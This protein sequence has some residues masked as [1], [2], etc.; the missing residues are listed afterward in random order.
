MPCDG[1][2]IFEDPIVARILNDN[3]ISIKVDREERPDLDSIYM[4]AVVAMTGQGGWPLSV[5]LTPAGQPFF[6]GT[7]FPPERRANLPSFSDVLRGVIK[8]WDENRLNVLE[9]GD[10][11]ANYLK[12][13][14]DLN[15]DQ[16]E[17][18]FQTLEDAKKVLVSTYD[19]RFGG[20]GS[21]PKFPQPM[22]I[23]FLIRRA[24]RGDES[25]LK[26]VNH[27]LAAMSQGGMFDLVGGGFHRYSTDESWYVPHFEK[28]LY[29]NAQLSQVYLH[30]FCMTGNPTWRRICEDSLDFILRELSD[31]LGGFYSS[32]DADTDEGEG[33]YYQ[34]TADE[35]RKSLHHPEDIDFIFAAYG[36]SEQ[37]TEIIRQVLSDQQLS[38]KFSMPIEDVQLKVETI[39]RRMLETRLTRA[40]PSLDDKVI[41]SWN[42]LTLQVFAEASAYLNRPDYLEVAIRNSRFLIDN[43]FSPSHLAHSWRKGH[44]Q[45]LAFLDDYAALIIA[46]L[47]LYQVNPDPLWFS[48]ARK[49]AIIMQNQF[50]DD[51]GGF[52]DTDRA[53]D[54]LLVR[55][56]EVQD[57]AIPSGNALASQ[58]L[59]YLAAFDD[60]PAW[61][62]KARQMFSRIQETA[63]QYPTAFAYWLSAMDFAEG[64]L[65]QIAL[66]TSAEGKDLSAFTD[67]IWSKYRPQTV[68]AIGSQTQSNEIPALLKDRGLTGNRTTA[69]V[70]ENFACRMPTN[71]PEEFSSIV[72]SP[73]TRNLPI[74]D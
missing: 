12:Q 18:D 70:C 16:P 59:L 67:I 51:R 71:S 27:A 26:V 10:K 65:Q 33:S 52:Y 50:A 58:A 56:K 29:D 6:G 14:S 3:F 47:K 11:I 42:A 24:T 74:S 32:L 22:A 54:P 63:K 57:N 34:W 37:E 46:L 15:E 40:R 73:S 23:E 69:Y 61:E 72:D 41:V 35:I 55:P 17:V 8:A 4:K 1:S 68:V 45:N 28:M 60:L 49:L 39:N 66:V 2:Q 25:L 21:A 38:E 36:I 30:A 13:S 7:Y 5:F 9:V 43:L 48:T 64:P 20:W 19:W 62:A 31:P 44:S 53:S